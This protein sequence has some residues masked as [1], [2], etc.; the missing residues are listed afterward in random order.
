M[1]TPP[2]PPPDPL[3]LQLPRDDPASPMRG[4][5]PP[6][7]PRAGQPWRREAVASDAPGLRAAARGRPASGHFAISR[8]GRSR[9]AGGTPSPKARLIAAGEGRR[10]PPR[11]AQGRGTSFPAGAPDPGRP[12]RER[13][14]PVAP[15]GAVPASSHRSEP[16]HWAPVPSRLPAGEPRV[17]LQA[18]AGSGATPALLPSPKSKSQKNPLKKKE[19]EKKKNRTECPGQPAFLLLGTGPGAGEKPHLPPCRR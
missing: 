15:Q 5:R 6:A 4:R 3:P 1:G 16:G 12:V 14:G 2:M 19:R 17:G 8:R 11:G 9:S 10:H 13:Q 18:P 7:R